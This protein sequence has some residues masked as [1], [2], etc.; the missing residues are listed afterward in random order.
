MPS[1]VL[2]QGDTNTVLGAALAAVK[3]NIS[4]GHVEAGLRSFDRTMPEEINRVVADHI[5]DT[6]F[7]PTPDAVKNLKDEGRVGINVG[8]TVV[9]AIRQNIPRL[10]KNK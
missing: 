7:A 8:N 5:S 4:V 10:S 1:V 9:D 2:V 6:L 3:L